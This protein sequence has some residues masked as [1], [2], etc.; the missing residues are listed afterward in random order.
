MNFKL[1]I[2]LFLF[3]IVSITMS[4][5]YIYGIR[6]VEGDRRNFINEYLEHRAVNLGNRISAAIRTLNILS[7]SLCLIE[8][9]EN[10]SENVFQE[11]FNKYISDN[12]QVSRLYFK[13]GNL[14]LKFNTAEDVQENAQGQS[15]TIKDDHLIIRT[16]NKD[17][18][19]NA[20]L[21]IMELI[22]R[23]SGN[24]NI[25]VFIGDSFYIADGF[26]RSQSRDLAKMA[27]RMSEKSLSGVFVSGDFVSGY[28]Y[29]YYS[30]I[31]F[32]FIVKKD[33]F[34][35]A[36]ISL[37]YRILLV[38]FI[39]LVVFLI[40][41]FYIA[42]RITK[43]MV[44]LKEKAQLIKNGIFEKIDITTGGGEIGEAVSAFNKMI[45]DLQEKERNLKESQMKLIQAE[46]M[47]AF[48][49]LSAGIA[50]EV[51][52]PLTSVYGYIQLARRIEKDEK[53]SEYMKIAESETLR[54]KQILE[55]LLKFARMD[56]HQKAQLNLA[57]V[58]NS[59]MKLVNH[60]MMM[61]KIRIVYENN[62]DV[63]INGNANQL[64]QV[65]LNILLNAMQSIERKGIGD[66][67]ITLRT[68]MDGDNAFILVKDNGEGI[69]DENIQKI[70]EP[71]FTTRSESGGT[72]L[73][74][75][76]SF[77]IIKEHNGDIKVTSKLGEG[78]EF[79]IYF[80]VFTALC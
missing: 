12:Y 24:E 14:I 26:D 18:R 15:I 42:G 68:G 49:Q 5:S 72:G 53:V 16:L 43:P 51:K 67:L 78:T 19:F 71:F 23:Y 13:K 62:G 22:G 77:G 25:A 39:T 73:G 9:G 50:H 28:S 52:N 37:R 4:L 69:P 3:F 30:K 1:K 54:C 66:G 55:D 45:E 80:P 20:E 32:L 27:Y 76:I 61:K 58:V 31:L 35:D 46:K 8:T 79:I 17:C 2:F 59:T 70:F 56:K 29:D 60:Q 38:G 21:S 44:L 64:Q 75:S 36:I 34:E 63:P 47:S 57:E 33:I 10:L 7:E 74:L 6:V 48:G 11:L 40:A 65:L 41:G